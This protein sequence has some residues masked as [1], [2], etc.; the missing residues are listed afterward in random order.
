MRKL[1]GHALWVPTWSPAEVVLRATLVYFFTV[2]AFRLAGRKE[3][4]RYATHDIVLL[5]LIAVATRQTVVGNDTS[6]TAGLVAL[7]TIVGWDILLS[8]L[9]YRSRRVAQIIDGKIRRLIHQ[10]TFDETELK[11]AR[12]SR[13]ELVSLLR[14]H[15]H[16]D[17]HRVQ[18]AFLE[19][20]GRV[21]FVMDGARPDP[22]ADAN[23]NL[24]PSEDS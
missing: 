24:E 22:P 17:L 21:T 15:G 1:D 11:R 10:G 20:S 2:A 19:R 16:Q 23:R 3:L 14:R 8:R 12:L 6:V 18:E 7:S 9:V 13:E 4:S 5:F